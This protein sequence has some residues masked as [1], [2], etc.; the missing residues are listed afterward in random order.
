MAT[1]TFVHGSDDILLGREKVHSLHQKLCDAELYGFSRLR[2]ARIWYRVADHRYP[3][4]LESR[5]RGTYGETYQGDLI[6]VK[7]SGECTSDK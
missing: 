5:H 6:L 4:S 2:I 7:Y 3:S 1:Q